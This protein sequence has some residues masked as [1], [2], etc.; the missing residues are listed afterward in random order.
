MAWTPD[1]LKEHFEITIN[2][3]RSDV[4]RYHADTREHIDLQFTEGAKRVDLAL[5][6]QQRVANLLGTNQ[7]HLRAYLE[8][9]I[10]D[11]SKR[12]EEARG[13]DAML[14]LQLRETQQT[15]VD[16]ALVSAEK[17]VNA[18][19]DAAKEAVLK[20]EVAT[21]KRLSLLNELRNGVATNE[22]MLALAQ[23]LADIKERVDKAEAA[24]LGRSAGLHDYMGYILFAITLVGFFLMYYRR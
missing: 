18:A 20:A 21:E 8:R 1:T 2:L 6:A 10:N 24:R 22:Q 14:S 13:A 16:A 3:L 12:F 11:Q 7:D 15:A 4:L 17:A 9:V 5:D 23:R 19:L